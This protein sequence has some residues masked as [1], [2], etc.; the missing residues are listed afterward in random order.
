MKSLQSRKVSL[1]ETIITEAQSREGVLF[2]KPRAKREVHI[3]PKALRST[4][5]GH[6][7]LYGSLAPLRDF[8]KDLLFLKPRAKR[9]VH[10]ASKA[11]RSTPK[12]H[13]CLYGSLAP[14]RN[15]RKDLLCVPSCPLWL[16][17]LITAQA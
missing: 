13:A 2:L 12:G 4:P 17:V 6:A 3:A 9:E 8:R 14:L 16:K 15:F 5:K 7:C 1:R 10:I 11:L